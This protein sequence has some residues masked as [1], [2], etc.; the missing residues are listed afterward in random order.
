MQRKESNFEAGNPKT[1]FLRRGFA[2]T[3]HWFFSKSGLTKVEA[4]GNK[5]ASL[6]DV[7]LCRKKDHEARRVGGGNC[8]R[9]QPDT[10]NEFQW[11]YGKFLLG[12][13]EMGRED[14]ALLEHVANWHRLTP[15]VKDAIVALLRGC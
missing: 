2:V 3:S 4:A 5:P 7:S 6:V 9:G 11:S 14:E 8:T 12:W 10:N 1:P 15:S 13:P